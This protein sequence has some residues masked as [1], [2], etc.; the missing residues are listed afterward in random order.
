MPLTPGSRLG[1]YEVLGPFGPEGWR[2]LPGSRLA[3][4]ARRGD[5]GPALGARHGPVAAQA[6]REGGASGVALNHPNIVTIYEISSDGPVT[7]IAMERVEGKTLRE[8]LFA[9]PMPTKKLLPIAAQIADGLA[10][11]HEAGI[12]HRDLKPE[13]V[14]VTKDGLVKILDFGLA[15]RTD[16]GPGSNS[17]EGSHIPTETGTSPGVVLGTVGYMSPEQAAG[18]RSTSAGPVRLRLDPL[19]DGEGQARVPEGDRRGHALGDP[20]EEPKPLGEIDPQAPAPLRWILER[21]LSKDPEGRYASTEDL[22]RELVSVRDHLT[23]A[24]G[25]RRDARRD[26]AFAGDSAPPSARR[27]SRRRARALVPLRPRDGSPRHPAGKGVVP[28]SSRP[29]G[30]ISCAAALRRTVERSST[31]PPG[32]A[33]QPSSFP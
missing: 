11:A 25:I 6:L 26:I 30:A 28:A 23:E 31:A 9:G 18:I 3:A 20:D 21:C 32:T 16:P 22:A 17:D 2:G 27:D 29:G 24:A 33:S 12:V 10:R 13:N 7:Y 14:M 5:Q 1:G 4:R 15:K 19:R 8:L